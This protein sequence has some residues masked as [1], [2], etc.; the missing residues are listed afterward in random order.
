MH[1]RI[2]LTISLLALAACSPP[3]AS[4]P[5]TQSEADAAPETATVKATERVPV[6]CDQVR[7]MFDDLV[8]RKAAGLSQLEA[9]AELSDRGAYTEGYVVDAV[10]GLAPDG[11]VAVARVDVM[12]KCRTVHKTGAT[13]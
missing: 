7:A 5:S 9:L 11:N 6:E 13:Y 3:P 8:T 1:K 10:Y 4:T 12:A 2:F